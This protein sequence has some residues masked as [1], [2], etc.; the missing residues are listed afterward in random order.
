MIPLDIRESVSAATHGLAL[1][2]AIPAAALLLRRAR[3]EAR[4]QFAIAAYAF[5]LAT[6]LA[7]ST[8]SHAL[9]FLEQGSR[10]ANTIDH[11]GIYLLIAGTYTPIAATLLPS[12]RRRATL[13]AVWLAVVLGV[14]LNILAGP[15]PAYLA[16]SFYLAMGWGGLW[17]YM[18]VRCSLSDRELA[19]VPLGGVLYS[20]GAI[21]HVLRWPV[22]WTGVFGAHEVFH[23]FVIAGATSHFLFIWRYTARPR[24]LVPWMRPAPAAVPPLA[25]PAFIR[26]AAPTEVAASGSRASRRSLEVTPPRI[27]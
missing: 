24:S 21:C 9:V 12:R 3:G 4:R 11:I 15:L 16:T 2:V 17:C 5:G 7:A 22:L 1:L 27:P 13:V 14:I 6:C 19:L 8:A 25:F 20:V 23:I 26:G 10:S 18:G